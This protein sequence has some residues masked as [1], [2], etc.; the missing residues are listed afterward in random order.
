[1]TIYSKSQHM[2]MIRISHDLPCFVDATAANHA[3]SWLDDV[4][5]RLDADQCNMS[6]EMPCLAEPP[7]VS[8]ATSAVSKTGHN[9]N[10]TKEKPFMPKPPFSCSLHT[11]KAVEEQT[12]L[13][14]TRPL[15]EAIPDLLWSFTNS[16]V[17]LHVSAVPL[18]LL[19][20]HPQH[21]ILCQ[22]VLWGPASLL[23]GIG[24]DQ[25]VGTC[26]SPCSQLEGIG[27]D[28]TVDSCDS[29]CTQSTQGGPTTCCYTDLCFMCV[30]TH[31]QHMCLGNG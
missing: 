8:K 30:K 31:R 2:D 14:P 26:N 4:T 5:F 9:N 27:S 21:V 1:M 23:E 29:Q 19:E 12:H 3:Q 15:L 22:S 7:P 16:Q 6:T 11:C 17:F 24:S 25:K 13:T 28:E 10:T 18:L 20:H